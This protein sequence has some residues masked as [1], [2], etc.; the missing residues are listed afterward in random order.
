MFRVVLPLTLQVIIPTLTGKFPEARLPAGERCVRHNRLQ[1]YPYLF[2]LAVFLTIAAVGVGLSALGSPTL[3][4][5]M[6]AGGAFFLAVFRVLVAPKS[7]P[8]G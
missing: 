1:Q 5:Y 3:Q 8:S 2:K 4:S 7:S 6:S